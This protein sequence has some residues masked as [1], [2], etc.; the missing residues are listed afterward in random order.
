MDPYLEG[1]WSTSFQPMI[2]S[3][4]ARQLNKK[5]SHRY[6]ALPKRRMV[7]GRIEDHARGLSI[8]ASIPHVWVEVVRPRERQPV[9]VIEYLTPTNKRGP[10]HKE[11]LWRRK[12]FLE[13]RVHLVEIDLDRLGERV[14]MSASLLRTP[15]FV[16]V[17][18]CGEQPITDVWPIALSQPLPVIPI[19]L[20]PGD[21][22]AILDLQ[23][24]MN[25]AYDDGAF[26]YVIDYRATPE[27]PLTAEQSAWVDQHLHAAGLRP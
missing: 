16:F 15:Y 2:V 26:G 11:Y 8:P 24:A 9:A 23:L 13:D 27:I 5:L 1:E 7:K 18:R 21:A 17:I 22:D 20:L 3:E 25:A 4:F 10:G 6:V 14:P 19:P 12:G